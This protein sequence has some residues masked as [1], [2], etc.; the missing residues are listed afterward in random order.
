[1]FL[2]SCNRCCARARM[3][4]LMCPECREL[5]LE[6]P[7]SNLMN[8]DYAAIIAKANARKDALMRLEAAVTELRSEINE[9]PNPLIEA[10][11]GFKKSWEALDGEAQALVGVN[12]GHLLNTFANDMLVQWSRINSI[13]SYRAISPRGALDAM[14]DEK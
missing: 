5:W 10:L 6:Q 13:D 9:N 1:M 7:K 11:A 14:A 4:E 8:I 12:Y 2:L 3:P